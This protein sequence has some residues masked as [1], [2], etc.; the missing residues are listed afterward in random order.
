M[1][2]F[3]HQNCS[4]LWDGVSGK[5]LSAVGLTTELQWHWNV[6]F[7]N[8]HQ[9]MQDTVKLSWGKSLW[10]HLN[11]YLLLKKNTEEGK[12]THSWFSFVPLKAW[13]WISSNPFLYNL[14]GI[15]KK[16]AGE[17]DLEKTRLCSVL[18]VSN[19]NAAFILMTR[20]SGSQ[21]T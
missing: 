14:L 1:M 3:S 18:Q 21:R 2:S 4:V 20:E 16:H 6:Q 12:H 19:L 17:K 10:L 8:G 5:A 13:L 9:E 11:Y 15:K 7:S